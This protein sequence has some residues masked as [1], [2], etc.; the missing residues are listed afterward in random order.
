MATRHILDG[1]FDRNAVNGMNDNFQTLFSD[2]TEVSSL[3]KNINNNLNNY[4]NSSESNFDF[5]F[6]SVDKALKMSDEVNET[7]TIAKQANEDNKNIQA[8]IDELIIAEGQSDAEVI[9]ARVDVDGNTSTTLKARIDK[10]QNS[11]VDTAQ[12]SELYNK[13]YGTLTPLNLPNELGIVLPFNVQTAINGNY[14][15]DYDV[16]VN[17]VPITKTYY[18]DVNT[19]SNNNEGTESSPFKSINRALRYGDA[20]NIIV[21]EGVYGWSDGFSGFTQTKS[22]N[23]IGEGK[24]IVGAHRDSLTWTVNSTYSNVYQSNASSVVELADVLNINNIKFL[25]KKTSV[26]DVS[27]NAGSYYIDTSNNIFVRTHDNR[28]P[29]QYILPNMT[30]DVAK[31]T[32]ISSV[33]FE[34]IITTNTFKVIAT[35]TGIK[36]YAKNCIFSIGTGGNAISTEGVESILQNCKAIYATADGFNYHISGSIIPKAIEIDCIAHDNGRN[37]ADQNNGSTSHDGGKILRVGGEYYNNHGPNVI[38]VNEGTVSVNVGVHAH[39]STATTGTVSNSN[40]KNGNVGS[41]KMYLYNCVSH[42]SDYSLVTST[43]TNSV[44]TVNN[45]LLLEEKTEV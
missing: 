33:Y 18:I 12:K 27:N 34:N 7:L 42:D 5:L 43:S 24:V 31:L 10:V 11:V 38:D 1:F 41:S 44:S 40:F 3:A 39:S 8:Q 22:F 32:D 35:I 2:T 30:T 9:Q 23:L 13:V 4:I 20:D 19:G 45:S 28:K 17:K 36:F 6:T 26:A 37:G 15:H 25:T 21:K 14:S 29:D 16:A